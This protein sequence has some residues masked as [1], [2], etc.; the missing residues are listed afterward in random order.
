MAAALGD[1]VM[2]V[3]LFSAVGVTVVVVMLAG[4]WDTKCVPQPLEVKL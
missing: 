1:T 3:G 2:Q 4:C